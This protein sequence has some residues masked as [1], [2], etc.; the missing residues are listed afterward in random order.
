MAGP[1]IEFV[2]ISTAHRPRHLGEHA[3]TVT[4]HNGR[5]AYCDSPA[6]EGHEWVASG[7]VPLDQLRRRT[8]AIG[9]ESRSA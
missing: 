5:W 2:C 3:S 9:L 6:D 7:G 4:V 1:L 8:P